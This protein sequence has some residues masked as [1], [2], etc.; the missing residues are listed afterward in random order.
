MV[1]VTPTTRATK[2]VRTV[3]TSRAVVTAV[4]IRTAHTSRAVGTAVM[5]R[6]ARTSRAVGTVETTLTARATR[7]VGT[8]AIP[9]RTLTRAADT[10]NLPRTALV[11]TRLRNSKAATRAKRAN[12]DQVD[13]ATSTD[14]KAILVALDMAQRLMRDAPTDRLSVN[15]S[16][17]HLAG[18]IQTMTTATM[19][20]TTRRS[21]ASAR[22]RSK[23]G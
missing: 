9:L 5:T 8:A 22:R 6:M 23:R 15:Q 11:D 1:R 21:S 20:T 19:M 4:T 2:A 16:T 10:T 3:R 12:M 7:A 18:M 14:K 13:A 17:A